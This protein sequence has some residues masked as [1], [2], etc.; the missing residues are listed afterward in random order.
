MAGEREKFRK[1]FVVVSFRFFL[2]EFAPLGE[3][4]FLLRWGAWGRESGA[5]LWGMR[6]LEQISEKRRFAAAYLKCFDAQ[7]A[8]A[9]VGREDGVRLLEMPGVK[10]EL[11]LQRGQ[12]DICRRDVLRR[13]AQLAF[14]RANDCV[15]LVLE[16]APEVETLE[17]SLLSE[18]KRNEKGTVEIKL[19]DR[20]E[21][22]EQLLAAV[23]D[24]G[25]MA[26]AFFAAAGDVDAV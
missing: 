24:E 25:E 14:G 8:A 20:V 4:R 9:E 1:I 16:A 2:T 23:S 17:L 12:C 11:E 13:L 26:D 6:R 10:R 7:R 21:A 18:I 19:I 22:L 3:G 15:R 5:N